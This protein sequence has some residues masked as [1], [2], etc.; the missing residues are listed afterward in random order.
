M[1]EQASVVWHGVGFLCAGPN[2]SKE[3]IGDWQEGGRWVEFE[4]HHHTST[5]F[6]T[7]NHMLEWRRDGVAD[8][9]SFGL[10]GKLFAQWAAQ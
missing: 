8:S 5:T 2:T 1:V 4:N 10:V 6:W 7:K 3:P 9:K